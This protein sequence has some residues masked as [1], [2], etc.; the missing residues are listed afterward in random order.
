[1]NIEQG[2]RNAEQGTGL[3]STSDQF[4]KVVLTIEIDFRFY[5]FNLK[6]ITYNL[7]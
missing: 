4:R 3:T 7:F 6:R 2:T 5:C 1:M